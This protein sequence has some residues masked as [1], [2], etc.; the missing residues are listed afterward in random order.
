MTGIWELVYWY[1]CVFHTGTARG[2]YNNLDM[3]WVLIGHGSLD[4]RYDSM[5]S[6]GCRFLY[7]C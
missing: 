1:R 7:R 3:D 5:L 2:C 6:M 4:M